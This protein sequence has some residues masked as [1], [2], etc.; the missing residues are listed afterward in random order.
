MTQADFQT[1]FSIG[2]WRADPPL[3][4]L[5]HGEQEFHLEPKVMS[6]LTLLAANSGELVSR[7]RLL[8]EVW[9]GRPVTDDALSRCIAEL[10]KVFGDDTRNPRYIQTVPKRGYRLLPTATA[11]PTGEA[12]HAKPGPGRPSATRPALIIAAA[13]LMLAAA[14]A[15]RGGWFAPATDTRSAPTLP[16]SGRHTLAVLPFDTRAQNDDTQF[17]VEGLHDDVLTQLAQYDGW[18]VISGSSVEQFRD[19]RRPMAEIGALLG[20]NLVVDGSVQLVGERLRIN[21]QLIDTEHDR[22]V[23]AETYDEAFSLER[24]FDIQDIIARDVAVALR[25][26]TA[27]RVADRSAVPTDSIAAYNAYNKARRLMRTESVTSLNDAVVELKA[28]IEADSNYAEAHAALADAYLLLGG[29]F[30]G[31]MTVTDA[32]TEAEP[33]IVR[34]LELDA[35]LP[36]GHLTNGLLHAL[37]RDYDTAE[38]A[39]REAIRLQPSYARAFRLYAN[40]RWRQGRPV[41]TIELAERAAKL[42]PQSGAT[43]LELGRYYDATGRFDDAMANY[44]TAAGLEPNNALAP[45]YVGAIKYLVYGEVA[46]SLEWYRRAAKLDPESPSMQATPAIAYLELGDLERAAEFIARGMAIDPN[47][48]WPRFGQMMLHLRRGESEAAFEDA[49]VLLSTYA[50]A[51]GALRVL[52][53]RDL[54]NGEPDLALARYA[55]A[56]PELTEP[57]RPDVNANNLFAAVDLARVYAELGDTERVQLL[58]E[59]VLEVAQARHRLGANGYWLVDVAALTIGGEHAAAIERLREAIDSGYRVRLWDFLYHDRNFDALRGM[60]AFEAELQRIDRLIEAEADKAA[61]LQA[62]E[63]AL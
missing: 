57:S 27:T 46:E 19:N 53:D 16:A 12:A 36:Y 25:S 43:V 63:T 52:R 24:L 55:A 44:V 58:V 31:G 15:V 10:R 60:P 22:H 39:Y 45:L 61:R 51:R 23:W 4:R 29:N 48:F 40:T 5:R 17:L 13:V 2:E 35:E 7:D 6:V 14:M 41:A 56:H 54:G 11:S 47:N 30:W 59:R 37:Q 42:D 33:L 34:A 21:I 20:A 1:G 9:D 18:N 3:G 38:L 49:E 28:A 50:Q 32:V 26:A 62:S 8:E